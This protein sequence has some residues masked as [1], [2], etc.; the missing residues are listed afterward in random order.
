MSTALHIP[1]WD[2]ADRLRKSLR[3]ADI[4]VGDMAERFGVSR[5]TVGAWLNGRNTPGPLAL[6]AWSQETGV[7]VEWLRWGVVAPDSPKGVDG[8]DEQGVEAKDRY[9]PSP[10]GLAARAA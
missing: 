5:N 6:R 1:E 7:P 10:F 3:D 8:T 4:S 2:L 9:R